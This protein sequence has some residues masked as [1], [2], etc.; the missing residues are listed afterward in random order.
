[1]EKERRVFVVI[2]RDP[3][4]TQVATKLAADLAAAALGRVYLARPASRAGES[5]AAGV[6]FTGWPDSL[7]NDAAVRNWINKSEFAKRARY[8]HVIDGS[9]E[10]VRDVSEFIN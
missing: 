10:I 8:L 2:D 1:M 9:T 7:P 6:E 4:I 5:I 3:T